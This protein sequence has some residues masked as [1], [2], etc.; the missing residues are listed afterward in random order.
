KDKEQNDLKLK[1]RVLM[2][3]QQALQAMMNP[4]FVFNVMNAIQHYINTRNTASA[5]KVLTG[6]A[7]LIRKNLEIC[8]KGY[9]SL[10]EEI[11][12]L[13]LYLKLEKNRFG[14]KLTYH[15]KIDEKL[16][17]EETFIPS[18]LLQ[19]Y[20]ENAIWHGIMPK[21]SGG[22]IEINMSLK[23][24]NILD[25]EITDDGVGIEN[26]LS[27]KRGTHVSKGMQLTAERL[28]L[29]AEIGSKNIHL[30][31]KQNTPNGTTVSISMSI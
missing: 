31:V 10:H 13:K 19:P 12:Y 22:R 9:I 26:S 23:Q 20:V 5:N 1:N 24:V 30:T 11:E 3:E 21:E 27:T 4:H 2:L 14:D 7:R 25:I 18:M 6:F 17:L 29:L 28:K 8:T 16:D 15:F